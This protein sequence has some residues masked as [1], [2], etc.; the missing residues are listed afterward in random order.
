MTD[1]VQ[2]IIKAAFVADALSLGAHWIYDPDR[3][4][5]LYGRVED[6]HAPPAN[7]FHKNR[8]RGDF[9]HYG[10][11]ML[12][13]LESVAE[14]GGFDIED[15]SRRWRKLFENYDGYVDGATRM[16]LKNYESGKGADSA[17]SSSDDLAGASRIAPLFAVHADDPDRLMEAA[18]Q[19]TAMTHTDPN[20]V[21]CAAFIALSVHEVLNGKAPVEAMKTAAEDQ[22]DISPVS[23]WL[24]KGLAT[25]EKDTVTV[26]GDFGRSCH[27]GEMMPGVIHLIGKYESDLKEALIQSVMAGG[28][29]AARG[30]MVATVLAAHEGIGNLPDS[31]FSEM[32]AADR[33]EALL[34]RIKA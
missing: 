25:V 6:L 30:T 31:W 18:R 11:Q 32:T 26:I 4:Q 3:I 19:Q 16:T 10:D 28:D 1:R 23:A 7:S 5:S 29:S 8:G 9:T 34:K 33:I 22:F 24:Q 17:G 13:L 14:T 12:V 15:F 20:T 2:A 21:D 27:T